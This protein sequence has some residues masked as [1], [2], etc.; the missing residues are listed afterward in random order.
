MA[1][2]VPKSSARSRSPRTTRS[3]SPTSPV[4]VT[5]LIEGKSCS[6]VLFQ[7][8]SATIHDIKTKI[9][10][11]QNIPTELQSLHL[12]SDGEQLE[13]S[14][15]LFDV[16]F[17]VESL[18]VLYLKVH[19]NIY[20]AQLPDDEDVLTVD[21]DD[22]CTVHN[23]KC[24]IEHVRGIAV[25]RQIVMFD[26]EELD[27]YHTLSSYNI[28]KESFVYFKLGVH[29]NISVTNL[30][31]SLNLELKVK[32]TDT[33]NWVRA[34]ITIKTGTPT[35]QQRLLF[36]TQELEDGKALS[37]YNIQDNDI[38]TLIKVEKTF[39]IELI[40]SATGDSILV[41]V[42]A[43]DTIEILKDMI[44]TKEGMPSDRPVYL[45]LVDSNFMGY[46]GCGQSNVPKD[47]DIL[48]TIGVREGSVFFFV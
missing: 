3:C 30:H 1:S 34:M 6:V 41:N 24:K 28:Q 36:G 32:V 25:Q 18:G 21:V 4:D 11:R 29:F 14:C 5:V 7:L 33:I 12:C 9:Q 19:F 46:V 42:R 17:R 10:Q 43:T 16:D 44:R 38:L 45:Q 13:D 31:G 37:D 20:V 48:G 47:T 23:L 15:M 35:D 22:W 8:L 27:D 2:P 39:E 26:G 40:K